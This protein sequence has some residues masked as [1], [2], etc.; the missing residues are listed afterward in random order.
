MALN[1]LSYH[2]AISFCCTL[3]WFSYAADLWSVTLLAAV[4]VWEFCSNKLLWKH[5][6]PKTRRITGLCCLNARKVDFSSTLQT[7]WLE[8]AL[9]TRMASTAGNFISHFRTACQMLLAKLPQVDQKHTRPRLYLN[10]WWTK[11]KTGL[12]FASKMGVTCN[13][14]PVTCS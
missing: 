7:L 4:I 9:T 14:L 8:L 1:L 2:M 10:A 6:L 13:N 11:K 5:T 3:T 12:S